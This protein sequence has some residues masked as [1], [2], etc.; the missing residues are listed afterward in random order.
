MYLDETTCHSCE[1]DTNKSDDGK[2]CTCKDGKTM[3]LDVSPS[4]I[5]I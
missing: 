5:C 3:V 1:E 4:H 2:Q